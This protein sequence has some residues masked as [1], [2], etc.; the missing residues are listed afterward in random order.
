[1]SASAERRLAVSAGVDALGGRRGVTSGELVVASDLAFFAHAAAEGRVGAR[2]EALVREEGA[3][4]PRADRAEREENGA[5]D[6]GAAVAELS[7]RFAPAVTHEAESDKV[8]ES[9][10]AGEGHVNDDVVL[11]S[12]DRRE[13]LEKPLAN[14]ESG[15]GQEA[16]DADEGGEVAGRRRAVH[17][18]DIF[19]LG[20]VPG[21]TLR[22][23][24]PEHDDGENL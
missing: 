23:N 8:E 11:S 12:L 13:L 19:F 18:T 14:E 4:G 7:V 9:P 10:D 16:D 20:I 5:D 17:D 24:Q 22:R 1:M 6:I 2:L 21:P 15:G 3:A